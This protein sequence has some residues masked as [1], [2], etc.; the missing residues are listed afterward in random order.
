MG[1][2]GEIGRGGQGGHPSF[3]MAQY[4]LAQLLHQVG[5][6]CARE[7]KGDGEEKEEEEE[8]DR[9][10]RERERERSVRSSFLQQG[11]EPSSPTSTSGRTCVCMLTREGRGWGA[12]GM[13]RE[14]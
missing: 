3:G 6:V 1:V 9:G 2:G 8:R 11:S 7:R 5:R 13:R 4:R 10:E 14:I 12:V